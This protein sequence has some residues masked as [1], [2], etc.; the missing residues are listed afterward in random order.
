MPDNS[1]PRPILQ[2]SASFARLASFLKDWRK[3]REPHR[4]VDVENL[5]D[6]LL[7][8]RPG[9]KA[10]RLPLVSVP[11][12]LVR[13]QFDHALSALSPA[14]RQA[15]QRGDAIDVW[16]VAGLGRNEVR[17]ARVLTWLLDPG[18]SHGAGD[19]YLIEIWNRIDGTSKAGFQLKDV[20][21]AVRESYPLGNGDHRVDIEITGANF[22]LFL[23]I[24]IDA[25]E[26]K[27]DQ[28][29]LYAQ[30][31]ATKAVSLRKQHWAV[32]Y[33]S[34]TSP[35]DPTNCIQLRWA[36]VSRAIK[37]VA[38]NLGAEAFSTRLALLFA[39]HV[40]RLH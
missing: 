15:R 10:N 24:K 26:S 39:A 25:L 22:L 16:S 9:L 17:T 3:S 38:R 19:A 12:T 40:G 6:V 18:G 32:L 7:R 34:E 5:R 28:V 21:G 20:Q 8:I 31:A 11:E 30:L 13:A 33:L 23:E 4:T 2:P 1:L 36:D 37:S 35:S 27:K 14:L 29:A